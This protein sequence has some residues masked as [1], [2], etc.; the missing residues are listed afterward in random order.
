MATL[1]GARAGIIYG[2]YTSPSLIPDNN[3]VGCA[4]KAV[5][6]NYPTSIIGVG[7][8]LNISGSSGKCVP[9][10]M[11]IGFDGPMV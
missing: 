9:K 3:A 4:N 11:E 7:V 1:V 8:K 2:V 6:S 5:V 10:L